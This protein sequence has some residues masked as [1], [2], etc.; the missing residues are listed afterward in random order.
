MHNEAVK[1][2]LN[3]KLIA[4]EVLD[5]KKFISGSS[6]PNFYSDNSSESP[7]N[8]TIHAMTGRSPK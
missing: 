1:R 4:K 7:P 2:D 8:E 3:C 6:Q 5:F